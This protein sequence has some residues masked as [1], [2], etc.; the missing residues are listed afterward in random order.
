MSL[1][2]NTYFSDASETTGSSSVEVPGHW[3]KAAL[4]SFSYTVHNSLI[5]YA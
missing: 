4:P 2:G 5:H 1:M 3:D